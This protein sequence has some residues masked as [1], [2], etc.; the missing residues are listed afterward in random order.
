MSYEDEKLIW[1]TFGKDFPLTT[2]F[3]KATPQERKQIPIASGVIDYFPDALA[4]V[5][6]CSLVMNSIIPVHLYTGIDQRVEMKVM[7]L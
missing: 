5:A 7:L 4:A 3:K 1:N 2:D 6:Q